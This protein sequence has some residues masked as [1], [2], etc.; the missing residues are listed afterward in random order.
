MSDI[1]IKV[2]DVVNQGQPAG[3]TYKQLTVS[4]SNL[5]DGKVEGKKVMD[6]VNADVFTTLANTKPGAVFTVNRTKVN[7]FWNWVGIKSTDASE[8]PAAVTS[9]KAAASAT[10]GSQGSPARVGSWETPSERA[11]KQVLIVRQSSVSNAIEI[12]KTHGEAVDLQEVL[13]N[14]KQI[15]DYVFSNGVAGMVDDSIPE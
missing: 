8:V 14:A 1:N 7:G 12:L 11:N 5:A 4:F 9:P 10:S 2:L 13:A 3:K 6:F 15:E